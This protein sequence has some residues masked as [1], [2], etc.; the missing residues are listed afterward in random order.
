MR[1]LKKFLALM[2][3]MI[4]AMSLMLTANATSTAEDFA[5]GSG[6]TPEFAEAVDVLSGMKVFS[7][8]NGNFKPAANI[9]RAEMAAVIYRLVSGDVTDSKAG[10]YSNY[11]PFKDVTSDKWYAGYVGYCWNAGLIKGRDA[12]T[13]DPTGNVTGYEA[14]AMLLRAV[15][16]DKQG[17]FTG[18]TWQVNVASLS[19]DLGILDDIYT[20]HY[21]GS[22]HGAARRD[23]IASMVFR[24][25]AYVPTVTWS[26]AMGYNKYIGVPI[27]GGN[28]LVLNR[29][30][31]YKTFGLIC[32]RGI[33]V[34][35]QDTGET[36][37]RISFSVQNADPVY[38]Y[39]TVNLDG[40]RYSGGYDPDDPTT[41]G[42]V[43]ANVIVT[44][45]AKTELDLFAHEVDIWFDAR[46]TELNPATF[47]RG[48]ALNWRDSKQNND[49]HAYAY[50]DRSTLT[51]V[52]QL[53]DN[54]DDKLD[55]NDVTDRD[56]LGAVAAGKGFTVNASTRVMYNEA[57]ERFLPLNTAGD[58]TV[59]AVPSANKAAYADD[60]TN[61][62]K[63]GNLYLLISNSTDKSLDVVIGLNIQASEITGVD[64]VNAVK[65][66]TVLQ[67]P[68]APEEFIDETYNQI[69]TVTNAATIEQGQL[70]PNSTTTLGQYEIGV[71]INGTAPADRLPGGANVGHTKPTNRN[72]HT[73]ISG[74]ALGYAPSYSS[75]AENAWYKLV[76]VTNI[77]EGTV[78]S[79]SAA[80]GKVNLADGTVLEPSILYNNVV[81]N[82]IPQLPENLQ[83]FNTTYRF[84]L[85]PDGKYLGAER[86]FS[87]SFIYGTYL[88]YDQKV[89]SSK[90]E[91]YL[92]GVT[93]DGQTTTIPVTTIN[94]NPI[95][96]TNNLGVPYRDTFG[97]AGFVNGIGEGMYR[98]FAIGGTNASFRFSA[99]ANIG[100]IAG[101]NAD[102]TAEENETASPAATDAPWYGPENG[103]TDP[104]VKFNGNRANPSDTASIHIGSTEI[105]LGAAYAGT[106]DIDGSTTP[107]T[108]NDFDELYF[109]ERTKFILVSGYGTD[110]L[111][112]EVFD[113]ITKLKGS[114]KDVYID[115][116]YAV[117]NSITSRT[118]GGQASGNVKI[119][120][121]H[122]D[123]TMAQMSYLTQSPFVHAQNRVLSRQADVI[124]LPAAA[125]YRTSNSSTYYV[126]NSAPTLLDANRDATQ[127]TMYYN[128]VA[129]SIWVNGI[130]DKDTTVE[131]SAEAVIAN[132]HDRFYNLTDTG[133]T[134]VDGKPIYT[135]E[136]VNPA[137]TQNLYTAS[138]Q[139]AETA[140]FTATLTNSTDHA[141][142]DT[143]LRRVD[144][145]NIVNLNKDNPAARW[146]GIN[147][148]TTLNYAGSLGDYG[149]DGV[150]HAGD[151]DLYVSAIVDG[152]T[153]QYLYVCYDQ[154]PG[155]NSSSAASVAAGGANPSANGTN[156][157]AGT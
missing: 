87:N 60:T 154:T 109:T 24:T 83:F 54:A 120:N 152:L 26:A 65:T 79:Y 63:F 97:A 86:V 123:V 139:N 72:D 56:S 9:T 77:K 95:T 146:P 99:L 153:V 130:D 124:I 71:R 21:S 40:E 53:D 31:G 100:V 118:V 116:Q 137:W 94:N 117:D 70:V 105:G 92:T 52:V 49:L 129:E 17:E 22:L 115:M 18:S 36:N 19:R 91:Y 134:A 148:L 90:F 127:F 138:T 45:D 20:T 58:P 76:P 23:V 75:L 1:N 88:D 143:T 44:F 78:V 113:G 42:K 122:D 33:V 80:N 38:A 114:S 3:A 149:A 43:Q 151:Q 131:N 50:F 62:P 7:G 10:L 150:H 108:T 55:V 101:D 47:G 102:W 125:V 46:N 15:G 12:D 106:I 67:E 147:S 64:S 35:N 4:M 5:D 157:P 61:K 140:N 29:T 135:V 119:A 112:T 41:Y 69:S 141:L 111:K 126:G 39:G 144:S 68:T 14:L 85:T 73:N 27:T 104:E 133:K 84:Y 37:T 82:T 59:T 16:Y 107:N 13:F 132:Y 2:L 66:V 96:G 74:Q 89:S 8:D 48:E 121:I 93:L 136:L 30:L 103:T 142:D 6:I 156:P 32:D 11:A 57:F 98:G 28:D 81:P 155:F 51:S 145:A 110:S 34:G 25:A 128:G